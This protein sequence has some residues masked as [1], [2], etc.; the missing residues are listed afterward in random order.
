MGYSMRNYNIG[1]VNTERLCGVC[2][3]MFTGSRRLQR[4]LRPQ[5]GRSPVHSDRLQKKERFIKIQA[6][7]TMI[8]HSGTSSDSN[9]FVF[10][11]EPIS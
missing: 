11:R 6:I 5:I 1:K 4:I 8:N 9:L 2:R 3:N 10:D 7:I